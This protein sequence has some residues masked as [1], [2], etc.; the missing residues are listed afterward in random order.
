MTI[1]LRNISGGS[2][3]LFEPYKH[4]RMAKAFNGWADST[5]AKAFLAVVGF[6]VFRPGFR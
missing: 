1:F 5:M 4:L 6:G 3:T 2:F